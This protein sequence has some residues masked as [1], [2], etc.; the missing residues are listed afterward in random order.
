M[1]PAPATVA[2]AAAAH[3]NELVALYDMVVATF[4]GDVRPDRVLLPSTRVL[5]TT[6]SLLPP[7]FARPFVPPSGKP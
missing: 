3:E 7:A 2:S 6:A 5:A 4:P 1:W